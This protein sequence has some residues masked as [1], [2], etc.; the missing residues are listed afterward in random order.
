[1]NTIKKV[2]FIA[3]LTLSFGMMNAQ[4]KVAHINT[5][6]LIA[7][8]PETKAL[9][10]KLETLTKTYNQ[11]I[12]KK[13]AELKAKFQKYNSEFES[14]SEEVNKTRT[15]E[16][17]AEAQKIEQLKEEAYKDLQKQEQ[18]GLKPILEKAKK[19]IEEVANAQGYEYVLNVSTLVIANGKD[20]LPD[21][22][23]KLGIQ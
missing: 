9:Q 10:A 18:D 6:E 14:Q 8:M 4:S 3:V 16:V 11:E 5:E 23:A 2:L 7:S 20:L 21:V 17:Q 12:E 15:Q 22:K 19:A 1:M 13:D